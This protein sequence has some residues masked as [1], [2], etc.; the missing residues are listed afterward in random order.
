MNVAI[1]KFYIWKLSPKRELRQIPKKN[2]KYRSVNPASDFHT[3]TAHSHTPDRTK[4]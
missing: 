4:M 1:L 3:H 2:A